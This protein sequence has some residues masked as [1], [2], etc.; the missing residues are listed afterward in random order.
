[1]S[2]AIMYR[3]VQ[4]VP[5]SAWAELPALEQRMDEAEAAAGYPLPRRYRSMFG[6]EAS[7]TRVNT[8]IFESYGAF[9]A[10]LAGRCQNDGLQRLDAEIYRLIEW[11]RDE[12]YYLDSGAPVPRWMQAISRKPFDPAHLDCA[13]PR[14]APAPKDPDK[15]RR[16]MEAGRVRVLYRQIQQVPRDRWAEKLEQERISDEAEQR[17]GNPL[18]LRYRSMHSPLDSHIRV[19]EREY[20]SVEQLCRLTESFFAEATAED[21]AVM[22]AEC[23]RQA[24]F[25]WEREELYYVDSDSFIPVWMSLTK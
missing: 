11:E 9:A 14:P 19:S 23:R 20:D 8:R 17:A 5:A 15:L 16:D 10:L 4:R 22:D 6:G 18:P 24:F 7:H 1:M 3:Q 2:V 21:A 25:T 12:L 13:I